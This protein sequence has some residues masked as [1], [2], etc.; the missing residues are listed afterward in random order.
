[1]DDVTRLYRKE[2][3][4][5]KALYNRLQEILVCS[6]AVVSRMAG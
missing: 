4:E 6:S 2:M 1:M 3:A 5:R